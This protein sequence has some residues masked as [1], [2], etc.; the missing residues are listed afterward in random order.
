M[1]F[2][3][4]SM[5]CK[6]EGQ[7]LL[8]P[9]DVGNLFEVGIGLLVREHREEFPLSISLVAILGDNALGNVEEEDVGGYAGLLPLRHNPLLIAHC[10]DM[11]GREVGH[12]DI[13]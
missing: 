12:I 7:I 13:S 11:V 4:L 6:V 2:I 5:P 10:D 8:D 9:T 3:K 1:V